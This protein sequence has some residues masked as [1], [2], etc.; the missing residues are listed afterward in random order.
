MWACVAVAWVSLG[1][2]AG[3]GDPAAPVTSAGTFRHPVIAD[4]PLVPRLVA[5]SEALDARFDRPR[6]QA[7][8]GALDARVRLRGNP[9]YAAS[10][11]DA[12]ARLLEGG[13]P[14]GDVATLALG[15]E[16]DAW[17][18]VRGELVLLGEAGA[19]D[20]VLHAFDD[21]SDR[22]RLLL[23][24]GSAPV[25]GV[26]ELSR[27]GAPPP[28]ANG[29][30]ADGLVLFGRASARSL[31]RAA[32]LEG[33]TGIVSY[34]VHEVAR[35]QQDAIG[36]QYLPAGID[37]GFGLSISRASAD[38]IEARL[39]RG[40][41]RAR[42]R[43]KAATG[44]GRATTLEARVAG[45]DPS[46]APV[47]FFAHVDEPGA[48]DNASGVAGLVELAVAMR[49]AIE[50]GALER[51]ARGVVFLAG[52]ELESVPLYLEATGVRPH[53]AIALDMIGASPEVTGASLLLERMPE[54][55]VESTA[56]FDQPSGW[57]AP[58]PAPSA[59]P[60]SA[61]DEYVSAALSRVVPGGGRSH[62]FEGG[63]DH[64]P[65][66]EAGIPAMLVWHFPDDAYHTSLDRIDRVSVDRIALVA[67][68]LGAVALGFASTDSRDV[69][70]IVAAV[71]AAARVRLAVI[72][73]APRPET[74][75]AFAAH[76][77]ATLAPFGPAAAEARARIAEW[78]RS[79]HL[80]PSPQLRYRSHP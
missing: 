64:V 13:F 56:S 33:A 41:V 78:Y 43:A 69:A 42:V 80:A 27:P 44:R 62:P 54:P 77:D 47:A 3:N 38:A 4:G 16:E 61:L 31:L 49:G 71:E 22:D 32:T 74:L 28:P 45:A 73:V 8:V 37:D 66:L 9:G 52:M 7:L 58:S 25:D 35:G 23:M 5:R 17:S 24:P 55:L 21:E 70:E 51:P 68:A 57:G 6:A 67:S 48:V 39:A 65:F 79:P 18:P 19:P 29:P 63:S 11:A 1:C 72:Q 53:A 60:P 15:P 26:F 75:R 2:G 20:V 34:H 12:R 40:P 46:L 14:A 59:S 76:Y 50:D 10:L 30:R 36:F